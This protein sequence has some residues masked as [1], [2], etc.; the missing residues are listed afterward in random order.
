MTSWGRT[1]G[2]LADLLNG[3]LVSSIFPIHIKGG[4]LFTHNPLSMVRTGL[5]EPLLLGSVWG[6][7]VF[8]PLNG[9]HLTY[10]FVGW[11]NVL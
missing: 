11:Y 5:G 3:C 8:T 2:T 4:L 10:F 7:A 9:V 6:L 1:I